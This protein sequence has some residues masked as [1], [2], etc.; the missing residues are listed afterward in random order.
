MLVNGIH[1]NMQ[2]LQ[3]KSLYNPYNNESIER[4]RVRVRLEMN[5]EERVRKNRVMNRSG[6]NVDRYA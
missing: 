4:Q 1:Y 5:E 2:L 6:Q 3:A